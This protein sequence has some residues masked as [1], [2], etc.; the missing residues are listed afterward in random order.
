V[1]KLIYLCFVFF[2]AAHVS[3]SQINPFI[4]TG[5]HGHTYPGASMPFG[6]MQLSP[7]TRLTGWDG[8]SGYHYTDSLLYGFSHTHLSGTG[9]SDYGDLLIMPYNP[10][11]VHADEVGRIY[12]SFSHQRE[13]AEPGYYRVQLD[14]YNIIAEL[15]VSERSGMHHYR[16]IE[17][18]AA[19]V[20]DLDHRDQL[21]AYE[22]HPTSDHHIKGKRISTAW[23]KEQHFYF[24]MEF[25]HA[26]VI[27]STSLGSKRLFLKFP[28]TKEVSIRIGISAVDEI[29][30]RKNL[31]HELKEKSFKEVRT[32]ARLA[33]VEQL[34]KIE[35]FTSDNAFKTIYNTALYHSFLS[36]NIFVDVDGRYRGT[37]LKVHQTADRN[38]TVFSL[39]DTFRAT[40]PLFTLIQ[41]KR[42]EEFIR[43]FLRQ[44]EK[45]GKLPMWE[46]CA[47][48]TGCMI[49]YHAIPVIVDAYMKGLRDFDAELALEAMI[50]RANQL[51]LGI[52][53]YR[54]F[55]FIP[56]E[57]EH[58]SVSKTLEY[59]YDDWCIAV[60]A[61]AMGKMDIAKEFYA[62]SQ[63]YK[64]LFNPANGFMQAKIYNTWQ[65]PFDPREVNFNFTEANSWQYSF[66]APHDIEGLIT[67][68][69]G[70]EKFECKLDELFTTESA[71]TGREQ[72]D[73]T[74]LIGQYAHGNE[75]SHHMAF[76]YNYVGKPH[77]TQEKTRQII[78]EMYQNA[79]DGLSGN[80]DCGQMS[81]W[82][83]LTA[84]GFYPV[85][86]GSTQYTLTTPY[87]DSA[88]IRLENG[89]TFRI[90][91]HNLSDEKIYIQ[92]I[93]L[94]G[95]EHPKL[96]IEHADLIRGGKLEFFMG[97]E[98]TNWGANQPPYSAVSN[99]P[100]SIVPFFNTQKHTFFDSLCIEIG[101]TRQDQHVFYT[102]DGSLPQP[103]INPYTGPICLTSSATVKAIAVQDGIVSKVISSDYHKIPA[104]W[105]IAIESKYSSQYTAGGDRGIIDFQRGGKDFR[106]GAW[107]G[108]Q[109]QNF[110]ATVD[111]KNSTKIQRV[112]ANFIQDIRSWIWLPKNLRVKVS[113][114]GVKWKEVAYITHTVP[115]DDYD[116]TVLELVKKIKPTKTRYVR[117]EAEY[118][119]KIPAWHL[120]HGGE[121]FIFIDELIIE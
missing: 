41:Q 62:R 6:F 46:L 49:G 91:A 37:D 77:K 20:I 13:F 121:A 8:C 87:V 88:L 76:L 64:N 107:Q 63:Y 81:S 52:P 113:K 108:Y 26:F 18:E 55:G 114:D 12:S 15:T 40:H 57:E 33:W 56:V 80:E 54:E 10:K 51:E 83:N 11:K 59:A 66:F 104:Q 120:G 70:R 29:G 53:A 5:G 27:D 34:S 21:I 30:A 1:R 67:L 74:G 47:N 28:G 23:A 101:T 72:V 93:K 82:L 73:I 98:P 44:Y 75:P 119:G 14:D 85:N 99:S 35:V 109:G 25:S 96:F 50:A 43:T 116:V 102:L 2:I 61:E 36:P 117:F 112:G 105:E 39:W 58:E 110:V 19:M 3:Y 86:P 45:G 38:Y 17:G 60:M 94:N 92:Q 22:I 4:G 32:A 97:S 115:N 7:D 89:K 103:G 48:Y 90:I 79:P 24:Y 16:F 42:T 69:G 9:V 31:M 111:L 84:L 100:F 95:A 71:T 118:F 78:R 65:E 106:T 68:H